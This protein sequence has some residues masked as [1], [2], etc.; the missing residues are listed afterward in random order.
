MWQRLLLG[1]VLVAIAPAGCARK[2]VA[3]NYIDAENPAIH[4]E[5]RPDGQWVGTLS[6]EV[7]G[8]LFA[9]GAG[10]R[11]EGTYRRRGDIL[12]LQCTGYFRQDPVSGEFKKERGGGG[13]AVSDHMFLIGEGA[14]IPTG[15]KDAVFAS[16][17][18]PLGARRLQPDGG[19][20]APR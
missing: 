13:D 3:G 12:E 18:N 19:E 17:L 15:R 2:E 9:H 8:G 11:L 4:Y 6:L 10:Q 7:P 14:L 20:A 5:F 16:D 1:I